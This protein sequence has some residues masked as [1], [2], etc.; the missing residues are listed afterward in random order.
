MNISF[1]VIGLVM[2]VLGLRSII[3]LSASTRDTVRRGVRMRERMPLLH[4][5]AG[6]PLW[7]DGGRARAFTLWT[8]IIGVVGGIFVLIR[9]FMTP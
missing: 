3:H 5:L 9:A 4:K 2:L 7:L 6:G 1:V 8:G